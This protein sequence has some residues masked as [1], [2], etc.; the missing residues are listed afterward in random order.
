MIAVW[1]YK[2]FINYNDYNALIIGSLFMILSLLGFWTGFR[3]MRGYNKKSKRKI[4]Y[5]YKKHK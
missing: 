4:K 2:D 1:I 3:I 5:N